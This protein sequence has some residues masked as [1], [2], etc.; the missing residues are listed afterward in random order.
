VGLTVLNLASAVAGQGRPAEA[1]ALAA[2]ATA[3]LAA[4]L[5]AGHP[6]LGAAREALDHLRSTS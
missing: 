3:I 5:P 2:R 4:Q 1:A 6:H